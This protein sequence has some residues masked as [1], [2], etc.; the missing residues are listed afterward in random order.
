[1][2][3]AAPKRGTARE[4]SHM[5]RKASTIAVV[6]VVMLVAAAAQA[7]SETKKSVAPAD[8]LVSLHS[9]PSGGAEDRLG[10]METWMRS[11]AR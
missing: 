1:M 11:C 10:W 4:Y 5:A 3:C 6:L 8:E 9:S 2:N 7:A